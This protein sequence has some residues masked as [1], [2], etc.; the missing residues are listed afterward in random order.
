MLRNMEYIYEVYKE[1]SFTRAAKN[2]YVT[3]PCLSALVKKTEEKLGFPIFNRNT[4]PLQL[5]EYG[6]EY[7]RYI[8][9]TQ[10]LENEFENYLNDVRGLKAGRLSIGSNS[11]FSS[12]VLPQIISSFNRLYPGVEVRLT[13][14]NIY[15]LED[16]LS[17][18]EVDLVL[19]NHPMDEKV[20]QKDLGFSEHLLLAVPVGGECLPE[21]YLLH[22]DILDGRHL[23]AEVPSVPI[24]LFQE[25]SFIAL[26]HG[27]DTRIRM[28]QI[29]EQAG[30]APHIQLE[31]DQLSTAYNI[32]RSGMGP[33]LVSDTLVRLAA[34][35]EQTVFYK[36]D[37][38]LNERFAYFYYKSGIYQTLAMREFIR[39]AKECFP[40]ETE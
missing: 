26:R 16:Q 19:D 3:Q 20:Y 8:E 25:S 18:G 38:S 1:R 29:C 32:V 21:G 40:A 6:R 9:R 13:E 2:L 12:L 27:N 15:Y 10:A 17:R 33:T 39:I 23:L 14:G 37:S 36:L 24:S 4:N 5:T 31:V 30:F 11:A 34:P 22:K 35:T 28:D 7:I